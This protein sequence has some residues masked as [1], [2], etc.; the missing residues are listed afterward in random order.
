[1]KDSPHNDD[2]LGSGGLGLGELRLGG[3]GRGGR[4]WG[5]VVGVRGG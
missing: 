3:L 5:F 2:R 4:G 1:M